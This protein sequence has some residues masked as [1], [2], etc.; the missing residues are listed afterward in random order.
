MIGLRKGLTGKCQGGRVFGLEQPAAGSAEQS[1][2][3]ARVAIGTG[4]DHR[5]AGLCREVA[6]IESA[7]VVAG[8][9][10]AYTSSTLIRQIAAMGGDVSPF[11]PPAV[12]TRIGRLARR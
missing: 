7:F 8:Q 6:G 3:Q 1:L 9:S 11:V 10:F 12:L 5:R 2:A 4:D